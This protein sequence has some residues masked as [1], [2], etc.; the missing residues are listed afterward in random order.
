M[1]WTKRKTRLRKR[2]SKPGGYHEVLV[3]AIPLILSTASWSVQ[4]FVDRMF[5][6]WYAPEAI[7]AAMPAGML[8][9]SMVSIF[10]GTA[11]Y[12]STFVAQYYGAKNYQRIGPAIWQGIYIS[13]IGGIVLIC[14]IPSAE[15][16]FNLIGHDEKIQLYEIDYFRV[17]CWGAGPYLASYAISGFYS[18]RGR[19]WPVMWVNT[20]TTAVNLILDYMLIFGNWGMPAM[21]IKGAGWATVIAGVFSLVVFLILIASKKYSSTY[22]TL[23][24]WRYDKELFMR[25][26]RFG[27]P[28]GIQFFLEM[29]GFTGF[30]LIVGRLGTASLAATNIAFNIN[31]LAFMP[32]IG[33][34]IAI[35]V[36]VGQYLGADN[37]R[38]A[39]RSAYSGFHLSFIYMGSIA[40]AYVAV[41][42]LFVAP[43]A[44]KADPHVFPEIYGMSVILLRFVALYS[45]FD[46]LNIVF[47]SA[48]KG[49]GDT[50]F[51]M[52]TTT[53][54]S[55][56]VLI[57]PTYLA[58]EVFEYGL[59]V[60]WVMATFY[61]SV[62]GIIFFMRFR[63]GAWKSMRV[64]EPGLSGSQL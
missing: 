48:I 16:L 28:N 19:T 54:F 13:V 7:A 61:V 3:V 4:H 42:D 44:A 29:V 59:M 45:L 27:L 11:G 58:V 34:G 63:N 15:F 9:F 6:S 30:V 22:A 49:A 57:L 24:G 52:Y 60:S 41:P 26:L 5:L 17:I 8:Y 64:I 25:V 31:T 46:T 55:V 35:S 43:F 18:G 62:I 36:L 20:F 39:Q 2:W 10:M 51:V 21:G 53:I 14:V 23:K 38:T 40:L 32:M 1:N 47:A 12:V 56:F 33:C 50:R 37:P